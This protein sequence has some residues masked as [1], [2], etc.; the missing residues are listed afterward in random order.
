M[1][2]FITWL[3]WYLLGFPTIKLIISMLYCS[4][5]WLVFCGEILWDYVNILFL[6]FSLTCFKS[7]DNL[8]LNQLL[9]WYLPNGNF[10]IPSFLLDSWFSNKDSGMWFLPRRGH[11][12]FSQ[13]EVGGG[14]GCYYLVG[15]RQRRC[16]TSYSAQNSSLPSPSPKNYLA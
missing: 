7:I 15:R 10:L 2:I 9:L 12:C 16:K 3:R 4:I 11:F 8:C 14:E 5:K 1:L 6:K 13:L